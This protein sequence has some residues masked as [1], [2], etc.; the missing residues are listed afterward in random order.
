MKKTVR[1]PL[2]IIFLVGLIIFLFV[3]ISSAYIPPACSTSEVCIYTEFPQSYVSI[4]YAAF[5]VGIVSVPNCQPLQFLWHR[6]SDVTCEQ[7]GVVRSSSSSISYY[8]TT[9][10]TLTISQQAIIGPVAA[11]TEY[12]YGT[13]CSGVYGTVS[14]GV[15]TITTEYAATRA[16]SQNYIF[17]TATVTEQP[18]TV[19]STLSV[20]STLSINSSTSICPTI[21]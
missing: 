17:V 15:T 1:S 2:V 11:V 14:V 5:G 3:P 8:S 18:V 10:A 19:S 12:Q 9:N 6:I 16:T 13:L 20:T 21:A 4:S 7:T